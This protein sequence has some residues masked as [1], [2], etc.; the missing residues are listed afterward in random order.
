MLLHDIG[1]GLASLEFGDFFGRNL[2]ILASLRV[3]PGAGCP[4][5]CRERAK[6]DELHTV[7]LLEAAFA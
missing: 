6:T 3:A 4:A 1:Q 5:R 7:A 2:D